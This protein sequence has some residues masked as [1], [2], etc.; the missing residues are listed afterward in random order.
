MHD[1]TTRPSQAPQPETPGLE[2][3]LLVSALRSQIRVWRDRARVL[4]EP[5]AEIY[6]QVEED[7]TELVQ[8]HY[9]ERL[10]CW[11]AARADLVRALV[12]ALERER[13]GGSDG[14]L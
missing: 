11:A 5:G 12:L 3:A 6:H 13:A 10:A 1:S 14:N 9:P 8:R 2:T 7:V 4:S